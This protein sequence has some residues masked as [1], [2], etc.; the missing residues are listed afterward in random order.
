MVAALALLFAMA[1]DWYSTRQGEE[2]RRIER[3]SD[4]Q[5]ALGGEVDRQVQRAARE[6][7]EEAERNAWQED[8]LVDRAILGLLLATV[9]L[10][11]GAGILRALGRRFEPPWTPSALTA[12]AAVAAA[13]FVTYRIVQQPGLDAGT[14][15]EAG[16][17]LALLALG[18]LALA[19]A[20]GLRNEEAGRPFRELPAPPQGEA[21]AR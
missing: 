7:G 1:A 5:G 18:V 12:L 20:G 16:P 21:G 19:C 14:T 6:A 10:A 13:A 8:G 17:P 9:L 3:L 15:I 11:L 2:A 4:P